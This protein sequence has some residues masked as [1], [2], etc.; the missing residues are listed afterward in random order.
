VTNAAASL[1]SNGWYHT[2]LQ[3]YHTSKWCLSDDILSR[4][5]YEPS[6]FGEQCSVLFGDEEAWGDGVTR[7]FSPNFIAVS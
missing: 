5:V 6:G 2:V 4:C 3:V 7:I 1:M